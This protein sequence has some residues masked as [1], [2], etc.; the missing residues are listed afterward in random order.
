MNESVSELGEWN[1]SAGE[2]SAG[3]RGRIYAAI[4]TDRM[5]YWEWGR[6]PMRG[7]ATKCPRCKCGRAALKESFT[8]C[9]CLPP[10]LFLLCLKS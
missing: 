7:H 2:W 3:E 6:R 4:A 9:S 10:L 8:L 5:Q 1:E